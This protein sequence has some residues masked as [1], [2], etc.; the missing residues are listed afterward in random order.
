MWRRPRNLTPQ[1]LARMASGHG[2]PSSTEQHVTSEQ[3]PQPAE[4]AA[5]AAASEEQEEA[6]HDEDVSES[7][8]SETDEG[9]GEAAAK[10]KKKKKKVGWGRPADRRWPPPA[11]KA[12]GLQLPHPCVARRQQARCIWP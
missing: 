4:A 3:Q 1:E 11:G 12:A 9:S 6:E 8:S 10:K 5:P 2:R 7:D